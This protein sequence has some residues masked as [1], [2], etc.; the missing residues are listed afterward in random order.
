M[1]PRSWSML[2]TGFL[3]SLLTSFTGACTRSLPSGISSP[4]GGLASPAT[5]DAP[6]PLRPLA[7]SNAAIHEAFG[8]IPLHFEE[9]RGQADP[10]FRFLARTAGGTLGFG[11]TGMF[12][13]SKDHSVRVSFEG[14]TP[15]VR[16]T[17]LD[18]LPGRVNYL[19]GRD[20][21]RWQTNIPTYARLRARQLYPGI[22][23][24]FY[25]T[26]RRLEYDFIVAP[27]AD[28]G[29]IGLQVLGA[30]RLEIDDGGDLV[31]HVG[32]RMIVQHAPVM[33][34]E[35]DGARYPVD[36]GYVRRGR[37]GVAFR[38]GAYDRSRPLVIDPVLS[39]AT[40][41]GGGGAD[42]ANG[43]A[44]DASGNPYVVGGTASTDFPVAGGPQPVKSGG[45]DAFVVKLNA[46]GTTLLY[47]TYLGGSL[48]DE[49]MAVAVDSEGNAYVA[50]YTYSPES[51]TA[52]DRPGVLAGG[53]GADAFVAKLNASC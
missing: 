42:H 6:A 45:F 53:A 48:D 25:G 28:P 37:T 39:Y 49:A 9:N 12:V 10:A 51:P 43:I 32:E 23:V 26:Q 16:L 52:K 19:R 38:V 50:G 33:Y 1:S 5:I 3:L 36:G 18:E 21:R 27:G 30:D 4:S 7:P 8:R 44:V 46:T 11:P 31:V 13:R 2:A 14:A 47:A 17:T 34:Q 40:Y 22:D 20:S 35:R 24:V 15:G 41:V 29:L